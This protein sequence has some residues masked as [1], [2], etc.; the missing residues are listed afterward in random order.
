MELIVGILFGM[1][2]MLAITKAP[3]QITIKHINDEQKT[4]LTDEQLRALEKQFFKKD[5]EL[6][7]EYKN[8]GVNME[9]INEI[10]KGSDR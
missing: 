8:M 5:P 4:T 1:A 9:E 6:D 10:M 2:F 7:N 3:I